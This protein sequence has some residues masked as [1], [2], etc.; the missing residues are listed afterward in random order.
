MSLRGPTSQ[1]TSHQDFLRWARSQ[2]VFEQLRKG[3]TESKT[4]DTTYATDSDLALLV[5]ANTKLT[6]RLVAWFDTAATPDFKFQFTAPG[7]PTLLRIVG[8]YVVPGATSSTEFLHT[9]GTSVAVTGSGST[10][11]YLE[12]DILLH[13]GANAGV[14]GLQWAQNTSNASATKVLAGSYF[15]YFVT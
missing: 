15:E 6:G 14:F 7:S 8:R 1:I 13:N 9:S 12:A 5:K 2:T 10:G 3:T 4:S 11:G